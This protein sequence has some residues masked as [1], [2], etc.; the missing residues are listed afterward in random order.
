MLKEQQSLEMRHF[1]WI[2]L[3]IVC[4]FL[5]QWSK[6]YAL[7]NLIYNQPKALFAGLN[8]TLNFNHGVAFGMFSKHEVVTRWVLVGFASCFVKYISLSSANSILY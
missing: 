4:A 7:E 5:D 8:L 6:S 2:L 1:K 3:I